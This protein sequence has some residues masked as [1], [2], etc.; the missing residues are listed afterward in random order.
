MEEHR[1]AQESLKMKHEMDLSTCKHAM[2]YG[3]D[4]EKAE[5]RE[6]F[7]KQFALMKQNSS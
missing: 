1:F 7:S 3:T 5:A 6:Y 4:A 2:E